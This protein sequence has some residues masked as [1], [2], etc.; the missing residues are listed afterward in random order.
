MDVAADGDRAGD[1]LDVAL[2]HQDGAHALAEGAH[3]CLLEVLA[4]FELLYPLVGVEYRHDGGYKKGCD[5]RETK[6]AIGLHSHS[7]I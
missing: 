4:V 1:G 6:L 2:L 5:D 3:F 7:G